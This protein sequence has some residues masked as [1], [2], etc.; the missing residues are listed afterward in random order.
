MLLFGRGDDAKG[1]RGFGG[2]VDAARWSIFDGTEI[3]C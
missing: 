2:G 1:G 3:P